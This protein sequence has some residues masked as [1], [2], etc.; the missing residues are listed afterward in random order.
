MMGAILPVW[1]D[2]RRIQMKRTLTAA[3]A[4][5][6][7]LTLTACSGGS[8]SPSQAGGSV[9]QSVPGSAGSGADIS[10]PSGPAGSE[11]PSGSQPGETRTAV[12]YIG[13]DGEFQE[14]PL[15]TEGEVT[16]D[17]L[18]AGISKL[19]GWNLDLAEEITSGKGGMT[20]MFAETSA[21]FVG[22]PDPQ[23]DE[24]RVYEAGQ[25]DRTILDSVQKTLQ[26]WAVVPGLGDPDS[27]DIYFCGPDGGDLVL[28][29]IGV[30]IPHTEPYTGFEDVYTA[31]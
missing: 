20:V 11:D 5:A 2:E 12:L 6:L 26:N 7:A 9:S 3:C 10:A 22:P 14:Y 27:V 1:E 8:P 24:F 4:L 31:Y 18:V 29:N 17:E 21:L 23:A 25:L 19:T 15:E 13:M 16:P 28:E 30:T